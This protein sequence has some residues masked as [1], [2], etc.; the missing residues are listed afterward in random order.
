MNRDRIWTL[1][2][3]KLSG[4]ATQAE[5]AELND[6]V[7]SQPPDVD[8]MVKHIDEFWQI[9]SEND[10]EFLE[11]TFH[12]HGERLKEKGYDLD[13]YKHETGS[14]N[15]DF[16]EKTNKRKKILWVS[17]VAVTI[18]I[19]AFFSFSNNSATPPFKEKIAQSEVSTKKRIPY[20]NSIARWHFS[21][22]KQQQPN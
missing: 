12:L 20:K 21:L 19:I 17:A 2:S 7:N 5:L 6:L 4:E 13:I 15:F 8:F 16:P 1:L 9:P 10:E 11:A 3:R 18:A 22:V 14:L